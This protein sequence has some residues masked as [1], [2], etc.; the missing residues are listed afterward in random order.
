MRNA[1]L[2]LLLFCLAI[3]LAAQKRI[4][5]DVF[6][7]K[8]GPL[9][10]SFIGHSSL[11]LT[12]D[13]L[14]IQVDPWSKLADYS[15]MPKA[16]II[17]ITHHHF[18]HLDTTAVAQ[19]SKPGTE[20]ITTQ[21]VADI[22]KKGTVMKNGDKMTV[23]DI[24]IEAVPAYNTTQDRVKY[25]P[26]GRD[27]GYVL[28]LGGKRVYIAGDT[29]NTKEMYALKNIS[30]A[31]L[32]MNQPYTMTPGQVKTAVLKFKP[33]VLYPYHY[34]DTDVQLLQKLLE[35]NTHTELRIQDMQ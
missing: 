33:T 31:F 27:N 28:D 15:A 4:P 3:N 26:K 23:R 9:V 19:V 10:I 6:V 13:G 2:L 1:T 34:G 24:P 32:P 29:E 30:I 21:A 25:H 12:V 7:T 18:D 20:I 35:G 8:K 22:L 14:V 16:D 5:M 11:M 17:L